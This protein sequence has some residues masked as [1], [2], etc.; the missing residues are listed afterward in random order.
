VYTIHKQRSCYV[1]EPQLSGN[2]FQVLGWI[3][4]DKFVFEVVRGCGGL[5][6][7][8]SAVACFAYRSARWYLQRCRHVRWGWL[9]PAT[10]DP[11]WP[12]VTCRSAVRSGGGFSTGHCLRRE[13][14]NSEMSRGIPLI[15]RVWRSGCVTYAADWE[16]DSTNLENFSQNSRISTNVKIPPKNYEN[17]TCSVSITKSMLSSSSFYLKSGNKAHK[18]THFTQETFRQ[19]DRQYK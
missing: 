4:P 1:P 3:H 14:M 10:D 9:L 11:V 12:Q 5:S 6:G 18:H 16:S 15:P 2:I 13:I 17:K 19:T 7:C 8:L